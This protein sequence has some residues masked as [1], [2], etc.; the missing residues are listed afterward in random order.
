MTIL[1]SSETLSYNSSPGE[2]KLF[3]STNTD[4]IFTFGDFRITRSI[5]SNILDNDP[6]SLSFDGF[7]TISGLTTGDLDVTKIL[8][9]Q[10][11][12][13]NPDLKNPNSYSYFGS[14]YSRM[15]RAINNIVENFPYAILAYDNNTGQTNFISST[16]N[17]NSITQI[18]ILSSAFTNQANYIFTSGYTFSPFSSTTKDLNL[19]NNFNQFEIQL[20][21]STLNTSPSFPILSYNYSADSNSYFLNFT[22]AG[23]LTAN[24][25]DAI[26]IRPSKKRY[27]QYKRTLSNLEYQLLESGK[28]SVPD[29]NDRY[30]DT[31][32]EWPR[33]IDGFAP[34]SI[35]STFTVYSEQI[36]RWAQATDRL[37]TNWIIR[38][39]IPENYLELDTDGTIYQRLIQVYGEEFDKIKVYIDNLAYSH[40]VN[41]SN[42]ETIPDKLLYKLSTLLGWSQPINFTDTDFFE[43]L[44]LED[45]NNKTLDDYNLDLWRR[46]LT[47]INWLYKKKGTRDAVMFIFKIIGAPACL[48]N[49]DEFVYKVKQSTNTEVDSTPAIGLASLFPDTNATTVGLVNQYGYPNYRDSELAFQEGGPGRGN[50]DAY[51]NQFTDFFNPVRTVDNIKSITGNSVVFGSMD[52]MNSK[53]VEIG[54]DPASAIECDVFEWY[55]VGFFY[56]GNSLVTLPSDYKI[57]DISPSLIAP[58]EISGWT[59][60]EWLTFVYNNT[61]NVRTRKTDIEPFHSY[62]YP[63]LR[64][65]YLTYYYWN[66]PNQVSSRVNFRK[67]ENFLRLIENKLETYIMQLIPATTI[68][69]GISTIYRNTL[70]NR[71]KFVYPKGINTGSEFQIKYPDQFFPTINGAVVTSKVNDILKGNINA[72]TFSGYTQNPISLNTKNINVAGSVPIQFN[73]VINAFS[74]SFSLLSASTKV[75]PILEPLGGAII[76]FPLSG[77]PIGTPPPTPQPYTGFTSSANPSIPAPIGPP[78]TA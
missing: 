31:T 35:G 5:N 50:G 12:D 18:S 52:T 75:S 77:N 7:Q 49:F 58:P 54:L 30:Y 47:N 39:I 72:Y 8:Y 56:T 17:H 24:T 74:T 64:K 13:L 53:E 43:F 76:V 10:E 59:I 71:Q 48:V 78:P 34:D 55:Q 2:D 28:F 45:D 27:F 73:P 21:S 62:F 25:T 46:I 32:Y 16:D 29:G 42:N 51:I 3:Q 11:N 44:T 33:T 69:D 41:Y 38:T 60:S 23:I 22:L 19:Y 63:N 67:L 70:F 6:R 26:Y 9:V 20:S 4:S 57:N 66:E 1:L 68:F 15:A 37:K 36:L 65:I 61:L 14:Y 40:S